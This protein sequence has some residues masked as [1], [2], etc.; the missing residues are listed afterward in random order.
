MKKIYLLIILLLTNLT[1]SQSEFKKQFAKTKIDRYTKFNVFNSCFAKDDK[2]I[3]FIPM[4]HVNKPE[5]YE[6]SKKTIDSLRNKGFVIYYEGIDV[7]MKDEKESELYNRKFRNVTHETLLNY[8]DEKNEENLMYQI[9]G[10]VYQNDVD[11]GLDVNID[12]NCDLSMKDLV[13]K[14]EK[15]FGEIKLSDCDWNTAIGQKYKCSKK[16]KEGYNYIIKTI[17]NEHL[18][19][20]LKNS[21]EKKIAVVYG[22]VH[23]DVISLMLKSE[24]W[25]YVRI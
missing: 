6:K 22:K 25:K 24:G 23:I 2:M 17:R 10:Y 16:N 5:F 4:V 11:Y 14:Y 15:E 20:Q 7:E 8:F 12:V 3:Y 1:F 13:I 21:Q 18:F 19:S 9:E